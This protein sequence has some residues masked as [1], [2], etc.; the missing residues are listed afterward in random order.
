MTLSAD[1]LDE[2]NARQLQK[3]LELAMAQVAA[4]ERLAKLA[5]KRPIPAVAPEEIR[6]ALALRPSDV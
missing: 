4:V 6:R 2:S 1:D 3:A 5:D